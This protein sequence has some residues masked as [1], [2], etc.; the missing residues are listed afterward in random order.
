MKRHLEE[1]TKD[2]A[3]QLRLKEEEKKIQQKGEEDY[4]HQSSPC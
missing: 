1:V 2:R 3:E 4:T